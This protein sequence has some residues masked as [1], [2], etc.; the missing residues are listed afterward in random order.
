MYNSIWYNS[1]TKPLLSPPAKI[2]P[3]VWIIL[4]ILIFISL[5]LFIFAKSDNSKRKG[6]IFF[7]I[8]II[9]NLLWSPVFFLMQ[10][11]G[12]ALFVIILLDI[13][14]ILT[15]NNFC[16][17]SKMAAFLLIPYLLWIIFATYLNIAYYMLNG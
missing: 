13:F 11:I 7:A 6:Y 1:L 2:F 5:S 8:Q 3:P 9:L 12:L 15:I 10:N 16:K 4:Y 17:F 14:V